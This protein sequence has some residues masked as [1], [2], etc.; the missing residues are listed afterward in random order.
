MQTTAI[1]TVAYSLPENE[2]ILLTHLISMIYISYTDLRKVFQIE[3][4]LG[5][6][7]MDGVVCG[8]LFCRAGPAPGPDLP[9]PSDRRAARCGC[10]GFVAVGLPGPVGRYCRPLSCCRKCRP[11]PPRRSFRRFR[12]AARR[13]SRRPRRVPMYREDRCPSR[14]RRGGCCRRASR[15]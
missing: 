4:F 2:V 7:C 12:S 15:P 1:R 3:P 9:D 5:I 8:G 14:R 13:T 11:S 10:N 6:L